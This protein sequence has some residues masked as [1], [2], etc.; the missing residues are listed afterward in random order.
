M[1]ESQRNEIPGEGCTRPSDLAQVIAHA[2]QNSR[3]CKVRERNTAHLIVVIFFKI[4]N[5]IDFFQFSS[6]S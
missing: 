3:K 6:I 1:W 4:A 2:H 5:F